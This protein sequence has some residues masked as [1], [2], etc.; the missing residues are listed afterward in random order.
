MKT[1]KKFIN[2]TGDGNIINFSDWENDW[3]ID[4]PV[5][6]LLEFLEEEG[7]IDPFN[8]VIGMREPRQ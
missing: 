5:K 4:V 2:L 1:N 7:I 3:G 8:P 6:E